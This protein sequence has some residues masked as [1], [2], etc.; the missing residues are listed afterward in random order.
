MFFLLIYEILKIKF[1][2]IAAECY[3]FED[4]SEN[5]KAKV[6]VN[7]TRETWKYFKSGNYLILLPKMK[8]VTFYF[9]IFWTPGGLLYGL[10]G[11]L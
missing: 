7:D 9:M 6:Y 1:T 3:G 2:W 5:N 4:I 11:A 8:F 10:V